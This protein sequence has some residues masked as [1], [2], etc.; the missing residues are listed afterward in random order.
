MNIFFQK[1]LGNNLFVLIGLAVLAI[2]CYSSAIEGPFF[3]DDE[4]FIVKN[5]Y[6]QKLQVAKIYTSS[7][8]QGAHLQSNFYRPNQQFVFG[9]LTQLFGQNPKVFHVNSILFHAFNAFLLFLLFHLLSLPRNLSFIG[10][11]LFLIHPIQTEAV[12]YISGFA[13]ILGLFFFLSGLLLY[14]HSMKQEPKTKWIYLSCCL[15]LY[16]AALFSKENLVV[17]LPLTLLVSAYRLLNKKNKPDKFIFTGWALIGVLTFSYMLLKFSVFNFS[18]N[19]GLTGQTNVYTEHLYVRLYTF[20]NILPEY[21]RLFLF[22]IELYYAKPYTAYTNLNSFKAVEALLLIGLTLFSLYKFKKMPK[23]ALGL[24]WFLASLA[25]YSGIVPLNA[26]YLEHWLYVPIIGLLLLVLFG[27]QRLEKY[28]VRALLLSAFL[29]VSILFAKRIYSRNQ[30]WSSP[31]KFYLNE[32]KYSASVSNYNNLGMIYADK[33]NYSRALEF[34]QLSIKTYDAFPQPH[35][36][37]ANIYIEMNNA[38]AALSELY[39]ALKIDPGFYPALEKLQNL[40]FNLKQEQ[41]AKAI[42]TVL[43][44]LKQGN[45]TPFNEIE[46]IM[47]APNQK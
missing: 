45:Q 46:K 44:R 5:E 30:E 17:L 47:I 38:D 11:A 31:E 13:D 20:I 32:T 41:K 14:L 33:K 27:I 39:L 22:P 21:I 24:G 36:N 37:S 8:T 10:G 12:A 15:L 18:E 7:V 29:I 34:Y 3:F 42:G 28:K 40:Y 43:D 2:A 6:V 16:A 9:V 25:P 19:A 4:Q 1:F 23:L 26:M 35:F